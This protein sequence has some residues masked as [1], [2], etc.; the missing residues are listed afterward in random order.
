MFT[1]I[2]WGTGRGCS[3][4]RSMASQVQ[5]CREQPLDEDW[6]QHDVIYFKANGDGDR[7]WPRRNMEEKAKAE[8]CLLSHCHETHFPVVVLGCKATDMF[9][10]CATA[11]AG[12][13]VWQSEGTIQANMP[14]VNS[15]FAVLAVRLPLL[16][17]LAMRQ[18]HGKGPEENLISLE[19]SAPRFERVL[20][21]LSRN[22]WAL[23]GNHQ[24]P[25]DF[26]LCRMPWA[27]LSLCLRKQGLPIF[28]VDSKSYP[29][30]FDH[31]PHCWQSLG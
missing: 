30:F 13:R 26:C 17:L 5:A 16:W 22:S 2:Y 6:V 4:T 9:F 3:G 7:G 19:D 25:W 1:R 28:L 12:G 14:D 8:D 10:P 31:V 27:M 11:P 15:S 20:V 21:S 23:D 24:S 29:L 18:S